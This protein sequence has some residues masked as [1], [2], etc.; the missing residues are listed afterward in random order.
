MNFRKFFTFVS[1]RSYAPPLSVLLIVRSTTKQ[2]QFS[3]KL[4]RPRLRY[5]QFSG[6]SKGQDRGRISD[7]RN[8]VP[9]RIAIAT[10][11]NHQCVSL[12]DGGRPGDGLHVV[13]S[14][15]DRSWQCKLQ[16][17]GRTDQALAG[18]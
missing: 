7:I 2:L 1:P 11:Q 12:I 3:S 8:A 15:P 4:S 18:R 16:G 14:I 17:P 13:A 6:Y 9:S 10:H 5:V